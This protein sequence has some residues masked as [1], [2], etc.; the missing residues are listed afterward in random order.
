M[1]DVKLLSAL[2]LRD[3]LARGGPRP[4][5]LDVREPW[6]TEICTLPGSTCIPMSRIA[7]R[8][9]ELP[10]EADIVVLCHHGMRSFQVATYLRGLGFERLYNLDGGVDAWAREVDPDLPVY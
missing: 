2:Q 10:R 8:I 1:S 7:Q 5:I 3:W 6:E 9:D 4:V